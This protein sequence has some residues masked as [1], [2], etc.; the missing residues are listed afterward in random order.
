V[1]PL[2]PDEVPPLPTNSDQFLKPSEVEGTPTP[3]DLGAQ[4]DGSAGSV[5]A[6]G[7]QR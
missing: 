6:P 5:D 1:R 7:Q 2:D 3:H 4:L